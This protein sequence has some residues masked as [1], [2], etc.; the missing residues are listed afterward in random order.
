MVNTTMSINLKS[1]KTPF[2]ESPF[3]NKKNG[4]KK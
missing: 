4:Q 1:Y 3:F 2:D